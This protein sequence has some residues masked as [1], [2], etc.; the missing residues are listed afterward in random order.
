[1]T[2]SEYVKSRGVKSLRLITDETGVSKETLINWWNS[3]SKQ[4]LF[5]IVVEGVKWE[6][7]KRLEKCQT[8][9]K[10]KQ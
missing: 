6:C 8:L 1:M 4:K 7:Q 10:A 2:A 5:K 3:E 9:S